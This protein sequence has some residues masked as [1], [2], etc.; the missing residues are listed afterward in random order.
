MLKKK[1]K[2]K[3]QYL[4]IFCILYF[5]NFKI[6]FF[7][8]YKTLSILFPINILRNNILYVVPNETIL[9]IFFTYKL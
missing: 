2:K 1:L 9:T 6:V 5:K 8:K 7:L 3:K 4:C